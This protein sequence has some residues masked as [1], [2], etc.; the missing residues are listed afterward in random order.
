MELGTTRK[1]EEKEKHQKIGGTRKK[2]ENAKKFEIILDLHSQLSI[3]NL[4]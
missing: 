3:R 1:Y 4:L 2:E